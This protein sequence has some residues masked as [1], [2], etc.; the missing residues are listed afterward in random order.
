MKKT[1]A[2]MFMALAVLLTQCRKPA[3]EIPSPVAPE[4]TTVSM[5][6]TAGPGGKTDITSMGTITWSAGDKLYVGCDGKYIGYL[7]IVSGQNTPTG[8]FSGDVMLTD[9]SEGEEKMFHFFYLGSATRT[10]KVGATTVDVDFSSQD[11]Y[12]EG[13]K[14]KNASAY[15]VGYGT[16]EGTVTDGMVTGINVTLVS[17]V[18]LARFRFI[19]KD[20]NTPYDGALILSGDNIYNS[21]TVGLDGTFGHPTT[22]GSISLRGVHRERYVMLVPA[23]TSPAILNFG[24]GASGTTTLEEGIKANKFYGRDKVIEVGVT[25]YVD[26]GLSV[27]WATYNLGADSPEDYGDYFQWGGVESVTS[28]DFNVGWNGCP[29]INGINS[30]NEKIFTKYVP[31]EKPKYWAGTGDPDNKL[32]LDSEDDA[33]AKLWGGDWRMPTSAEFKELYD[34]TVCTWTTENGV[35]GRKFASKKDATKYI[36][37]PAAGYRDGT[38]VGATGSVG[39]YWSSSLYSSD[40]NNAHNMHFNSGSVRPQG[41]NFRYLGYSVRPVR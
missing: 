26:L 6:V 11:I 39:Y 9:I 22:T 10:L 13:G 7:T 24:G 25:N 17:K 36:F 4:C 30:S 29:F 16:A 3:V 38:D 27:K 33:A 2:I 15:H 19:N 12:E 41:Y 31:K 34:N 35:Y 37:L 40:P 14:L 18:A 5:T 28:T 32:V 1:L 8:T 23:V 21:M 20:A